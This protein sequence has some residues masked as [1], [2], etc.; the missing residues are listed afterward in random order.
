M[1]WQPI[2]YNRYENPYASPPPMY[3]SS[4]CELCDGPTGRT[5]QQGWKAVCQPCSTVLWTAHA[6]YQEEEPDDQLD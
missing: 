3:D 4:V 1:S 6:I 5:G 2:A